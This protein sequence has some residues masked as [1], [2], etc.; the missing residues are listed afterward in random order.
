MSSRFYLIL[1]TLLI[2]LF[3]VGSVGTAYILIQYPEV[4]S[5]KMVVMAFVTIGILFIGSWPLFGGCPFTVW[6]NG[7]RKREGKKPY[8]DACM[9][10]YARRWF[11]WK[12]TR[13]EDT[14][15]PVGFLLLPIIAGLL[16]W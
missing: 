9:M 16:N 3:D 11:G 10:R 13:N 4:V 15:I 14:W 6:E 8:S 12:M 5:G 7:A 2:V 1:H